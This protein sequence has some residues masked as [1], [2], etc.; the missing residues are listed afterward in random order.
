MKCPDCNA[1]MDENEFEIKVYDEDLT[2]ESRCSSCRRE[3]EYNVPAD[4]YF[5]IK[6][7]M[8]TKG[9]YNG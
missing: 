7:A 8:G 5:S 3:D 6:G 4:F 9:L 1:K 2:V